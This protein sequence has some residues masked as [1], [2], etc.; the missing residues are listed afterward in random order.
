MNT[1]QTDTWIIKIPAD[2]EPKPLGY[3]SPYCESADG[4]NGLY[5]NTW[6]L[7]EGSFDSP[8]DAVEAYY[9]TS[10]ES[11]DEMEGNDWR[12]VNRQPKEGEST[13][14]LLVD[15]LSPEQNY[16]IAMKF[17]ARHDVLV[18]AAFHDY[19]YEDYEESKRFFGPVITS[20]T[21]VE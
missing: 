6:I 12:L 4:E 5:I 16:R 19:Y 8:S 13:S 17:I 7:D 11:I 10:A 15:H 18:R 3:G 9:E 21:F 2:W 20:L 1:V 14:E